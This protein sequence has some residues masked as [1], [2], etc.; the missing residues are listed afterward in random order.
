MSYYI[1]DQTCK[2]MQY[3]TG[4]GYAISTAFNLQ[5]KSPVKHIHCGNWA[6]TESFLL[7]ICCLQN[8]YAARP[9]KH[10]HQA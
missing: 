8:F 1:K 2:L 6:Y 9:N 5:F 3:K 4:A 10:L 7:Q